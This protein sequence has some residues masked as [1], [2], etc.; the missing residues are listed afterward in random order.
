MPS[1]FSNL[2]A[3]VLVGVNW[4]THAEALG[5]TNWL[6]LCEDE[7]TLQYLD[8]RYPGHAVPASAFLGKR[9]GKG[10]ALHEYGTAAFSE[11]T[12]ARPAYLQVVLRAGFNVLWSD[13]DT[14]W[15]T[16][17]LDLAPSSRD[18]VM[19]DDSMEE[20]EENSGNICT[21]LMYFTPTDMVK[22]VLEEWHRV[23]MEDGSN[24]Q[25]AWNKIFNAER[26]KKLQYHIMTKELYPNGHLLETRRYS[27]NDTLSAWRPAWVHANYRVGY[28]NKRQFLIDSSVWQGG[29]ESDK[30]SCEVPDQ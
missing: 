28:H 13:M 17:F 16:N 15:L 18:V 20:H 22:S 29:N 27:R 8:S 2:L 9:I 7:A 30:P 5:I 26:R 6:T 25:T 24:D 23:C 19:V 11:I 3:L 12:C 4:I 1:K 10:S 21:G 14:A